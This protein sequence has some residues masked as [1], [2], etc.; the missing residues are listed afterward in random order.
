M[1]MVLAGICL[2]L[3]FSASQDNFNIKFAQGIGQ[4]SF[5]LAAIYLRQMF[6]GKKFTD[7]KTFA[8]VPSLYWPVLVPTMGVFSAIMGTR[9]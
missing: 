8:L 9:I 5:A 7:Y 6:M 1:G 4:F 3:A 2:D